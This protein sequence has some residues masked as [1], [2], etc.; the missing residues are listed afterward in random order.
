M[1]YAS[2]EVQNDEKNSTATIFGPPFIGPVA[3][4][5]RNREL[6]VSGLTT[7]IMG[8]AVGTYLGLAVAWLLRP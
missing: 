7:G 3:R 1:T 2:A 4:A 5:L 8:Y 6:M